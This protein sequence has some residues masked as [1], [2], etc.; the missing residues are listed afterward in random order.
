MCCTLSQNGTFSHRKGHIR[1]HT[2]LFIIDLEKQLLTVPYIIQGTFPKPPII[3]KIKSQQLVWH[4]ELSCEARRLPATETQTFAP[5]PH[6]PE[7]C[8]AVNFTV[9]IRLNN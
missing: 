3:I 2:N 5:G 7:N 6:L 1:I 4:S 8:F 9:N